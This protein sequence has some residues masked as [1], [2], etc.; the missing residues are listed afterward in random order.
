MKR[1]LVLFWALAHAS[2]VLAQSS[3]TFYPYPEWLWAAA[4]RSVNQSSEKV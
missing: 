2:S 1:S 4:Y 3:G